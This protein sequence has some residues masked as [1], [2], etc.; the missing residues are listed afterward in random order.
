MMMN[1]CSLMWFFFRSGRARLRIWSSLLFCVVICPG[2]TRQDAGG[3]RRQ[4]GPDLTQAQAT[5][6]RGSRRTHRRATHSAPRRYA[7][8]VPAP[9]VHPRRLSP[10]P[11]RPA[12]ELPVRAPEEASDSSRGPVLFLTFVVA[13]LVMVLAV[14]LVAAVGQ[15]WILISVAAFDL[16]MTAAVTGVVVWM[17]VDHP[18]RAA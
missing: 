15:W 7:S 11:A 13:V 17:L 12:F 14:W 10:R 8:T 3:G 1:V 4:G 16:L 18:A 5:T 9:L 6:G 2:L